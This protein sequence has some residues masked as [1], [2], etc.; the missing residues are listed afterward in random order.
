MAAAGWSG[1]TLWD[2]PAGAAGGVSGGG[3]RDGPAATAFSGGGPPEQIQG[4]PA[5][6]AAATTGGSDGGVGGQP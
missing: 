4:R 2:R 5:G 1:G 3:L 6:A